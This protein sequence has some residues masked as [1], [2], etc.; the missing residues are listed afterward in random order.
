LAILFAA[1]LAESYGW[2]LAVLAVAGVGQ[3][4]ANRTVPQGS[5]SPTT[6]SDASTGPA[7]CA[8]L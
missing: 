2:L 8:R 6:P 5:I 1:S 7:T 4:L 3:A